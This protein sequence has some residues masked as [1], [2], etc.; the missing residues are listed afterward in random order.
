MS[1]V[2]ILNHGRK[3]SM[4]NSPPATSRILSAEVNL[5]MLTDGDCWAIPLLSRHV[6]HSVRPLARMLPPAEARV[7]DGAAAYTRRGSAL[8]QRPDDR[9][10]GC[11]V[12][13][14]TDRSLAS[15]ATSP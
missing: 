6:G 3:V 2:Q 8:Q 13:A 11:P 15:R 10:E 1:D 14:A 9:R 4:K 12:M 5:F 7:K